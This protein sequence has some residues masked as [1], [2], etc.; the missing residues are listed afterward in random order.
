MRTDGVVVLLAA[1]DAGFKEFAGALKLGT[2]VGQGSLLRL[3]GG[4]LLVDRGLL[5][6][7]VDFHDGLTSLHAGTGYHKYLNDLPFDLWLK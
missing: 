7:R 4:H 5:A 1:D 2:I 3:L 6:A